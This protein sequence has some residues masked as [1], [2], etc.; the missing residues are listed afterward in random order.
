MSESG[1][2]LLQLFLDARKVH[3]EV[4]RLLETAE[5]ILLER[6]WRSAQTDRLA[7]GY[8]SFTLD[9]PMGWM[10]A[11]AFRF[12]QPQDPTSHVLAFVSVLFLPHQ[13]ERGTYELPEPLITTGWFQYEQKIPQITGANQWYARFHC[14]SSDR[15]SAD[16]QWI[17]QRPTDYSPAD[18]EKYKY[19]FTRARTCGRPLVEMTG[20]SALDDLLIKPLLVDV[21]GKGGKSP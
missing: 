3:V 1:R 20:A 11:E 2:N 7:I 9:G 19:A 12:F 8:L 10:P 16:G 4:A 15:P 17:E 14:Y 21:A 6:G 13:A 5:G 18:R